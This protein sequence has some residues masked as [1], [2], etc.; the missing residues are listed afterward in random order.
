MTETTE[1]CGLFFF[2]VFFLQFWYVVYMATTRPAHES[3]DQ[4][5]LYVAYM[6]ME[7]FV[8]LLQEIW[9]TTK[10]Q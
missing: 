8:S 1:K 4:S 7:N 6:N 3:L 2:V 5:V 10:K 9:K